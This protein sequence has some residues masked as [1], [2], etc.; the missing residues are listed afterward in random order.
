MTE[1]DTFDKLRRI[2]VERLED[3]MM[4]NEDKFDISIYEKFN[5]FQIE[6]LKTHGWTELAYKRHWYA[7][8][9]EN[10][11]TIVGARWW[12]DFEESIK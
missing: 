1:D 8:A 11:S 12:K 6:F 10:Q 2:P 4:Q 7:R 9:L 3:L 5:D